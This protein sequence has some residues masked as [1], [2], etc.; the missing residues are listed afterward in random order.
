V[1]V[2]REGSAVAVRL[3]R[4]GSKEVRGSGDALEWD[5][6]NSRTFGRNRFPTRV[7]FETEADYLDFIGKDA[8]FA[9]FVR[10]VGHVRAAAAELELWLSLHVAAARSALPVSLLPFA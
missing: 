9:T 3:L 4:D 5:E 7:L 8:E 6:V 1:V 10:A 2:S